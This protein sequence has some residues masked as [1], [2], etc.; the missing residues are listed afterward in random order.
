MLN[1]GSRR[2][3]F[4]R[5]CFLVLL[6]SVAQ[7]TELAPWFP[8]LFEFQARG[9]Y[10]FEKV[11]KVKTPSGAFRAPTNINSV[12]LAL[13]VTPWP[14][15]NLEAE[16]YLTNT[17]DISFNYEAAL[18]TLRYALLD[19]IT[20]DLIA[21]ATG[22]TISFPE[23]R[24]LRQFSFDYHGNVNAEFH[25]TVGKEW[26]SCEEWVVRIWGLGGYGIANRGS[27]WVH[28]LGVVE[29][30]PLPFLEAA[31]FTEALYG[32]GTRNI[33]PGQRFPGYASINHQNIDIGGALTTPLS[34]FGTLSLIGWKNIHAHN[35][36]SGYW[37]LALSLL[38][39]FSII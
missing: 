2:M 33:I 36:I 26:A 18:V 24:F 4:I 1:V 35:F 15:L 19:D 13:D 3:T 31:F 5:S 30:R 6:F 22:V 38:I 25:A 34:Y 23:R 20:G 8:P 9:T 28:A 32:L 12:Q 21:L 17:R 11:T 37:G 14:Y 29:C 16:L 39:P 7:A 10:F 27:P